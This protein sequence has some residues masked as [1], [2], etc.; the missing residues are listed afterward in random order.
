MSSN[1]Q[2][3]SD[4]WYDEVY[5]DS[6]IDSDQDMEDAGVGIGLPGKTKVVPKKKQK[7]ILS[8]DELLYDPEEDDKD[9]EWVS[10]EIE[11]DASGVD[12]P[13]DDKTDAILTCPMCFT[14]LCYSCQRHAK[15]ANQ[16]RAMFVRNC[17]VIKTEKYRSEGSDEGYFKVNC[18]TC[19]IHVAMM[20]DEE[21]YH[22]FNVI[23]SAR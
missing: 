8:N 11:K 18:K 3:E 21:V 9:E 7:K 16:F 12:G 15:Y 17:Q 5:F 23:A 22:F 14:T 4:E 2:Q 10:N 1:Q 19:S 20:D 6:D 13:L